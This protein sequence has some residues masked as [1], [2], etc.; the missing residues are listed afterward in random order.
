MSRDSSNAANT[1]L[2]ESNLFVRMLWTS[3]ENELASRHH[4]KLKF[5]KKVNLKRKGLI[6]G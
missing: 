6:K 3:K 1:W 2:R 5:N 4:Q